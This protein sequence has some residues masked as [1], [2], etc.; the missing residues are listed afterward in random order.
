LGDKI[1]SVDQTGKIVQANNVLKMFK[2]FGVNEAEIEEAY[3]GDIVSIAGLGEVTV[4]WTLNSPGQTRVIKSIP[5]DPPMLSVLVT[6]NDSPFQGKEGTKNTINQIISRIKQE[7]DDDV[8]L[9]VS[10]LE[11]KAEVIEVSGR[12][13]LHLGVLLEK[14]R[15]EGFEI[16]K[17]SKT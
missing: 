13:D 14:M 10:V 8:S 16:G 2:K 5:I 6:Y 12:G 17:H 9:K 1:Q 4:G 7:A 3:A 11:G 15:R